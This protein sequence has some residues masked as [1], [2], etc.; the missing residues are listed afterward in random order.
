MKE[1]TNN[2]IA[3]LLDRIAAVL[4]VQDANP[5]RV[6]AYRDG[7]AMIRFH[8]QPIADYIT[9]NRIDDLT[10]LPSIGD[11]IAA[12]IGEFVKTGQSDLLRELE[13]DAG[14]EAVL[15]QV[16][17]IGKE[18]AKRIVEQI[19]VQ[20]LTELEM[21]AYD[22]SL[23]TV[24]GFGRRRVEGVRAALAG[25]LSH[26]ARSRQF[27]RTNSA[28][29]DQSNVPRP[30][31]ALLLD[32]DAEYQRR[33]AAGELQKIAPR[34]FNP[35]NEE[36]LSV[37]HARRDGWRFTI[38]YSNTAQAHRLQKVDDWVVIYYERDGIEQ[39]NT[40]VTETLGSLTGKRVV[41]GRSVE[42]QAYYRAQTQ[43]R[44]KVDGSKATL[45][46]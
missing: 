20:N 17:G 25:M 33:T 40:V 10:A 15:I 22:G 38:L 45:P 44:A 5:F 1:P 39:Q 21:A 43:V 9:E 27:H 46:H 29:A 34:R 16:P 19:G 8:D 32:I 12:V 37:M 41:R 42:N 26:S 3:D 11:G 31:V 2:E 36:W 13:A 6:R 18:Y 28:P 35:D 24:R 23:E 14:P 30:S 7:A 4:E